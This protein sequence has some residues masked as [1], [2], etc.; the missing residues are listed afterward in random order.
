M[1]TARAIESLISRGAEIRAK[2]EGGKKTLTGYAA[3]FNSPS[4]DLGG[5]V[6]VIR[7]GAFTRAL[8]EGQNVVCLHNHDP[9]QLLGRTASG[10]L[11]LKEDQRGLHFE[12]D[13]PDTGA[14]R[15][16]LAVVERGDIEGCSFRFI[17]NRSATA[18]GA[19]WIFTGAGS[20]D[21]REIL[22]VDLLD[23]G[24][25]TDPAYP[26]TDVSARAYQD[27]LR[28]FRSGSGA[29]NRIAGLRLA[30]ADLV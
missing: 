8:R 20:P 13:L 17:V 10:T 23:V 15:D 29:A 28:E 3:V 25:C 16:V 14:A 26:G 11:R 30:E 4:H 2:T 1:T 7:P 12:C 19:K 24:P 27:A 21:I 9:N 6:E 5:F 18:P 22:D